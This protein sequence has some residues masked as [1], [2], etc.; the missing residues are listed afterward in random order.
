MFLTGAAATAGIAA[1]AGLTGCAPQNVSDSKAGATGTGT[2]TA[3]ATMQTTDPAQ[4]VWPVVEEV[5]VRAAGEG[6]DCFC[7]RTLS[8][9]KTSLPL[10]MSTL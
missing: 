1:F 3:S 5:E 8:P 9:R 2:K 7:F 4:A 10:M 6:E